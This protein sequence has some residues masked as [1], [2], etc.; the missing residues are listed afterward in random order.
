MADDNLQYTDYI[1]CG[2][3]RVYIPTSIK[4][5]ALLTAVAITN[6]AIAICGTLA[7]CLVIMSYYRNP[8]LR[9]I[10]STI[11]LLLAITDTSVTAFVQ[12]IF[13]VSILKELQG[14]YNC[15]LS[16]ASTLLTMFFLLLSM[17]T[18]VILS[19]HSYITLAYPYHW[20]SIITKSR[21]N[22][23]I[24]F[25]IFLA[26]LL[27]F[28]N[29]LHVYFLS[30][31]QPSLIISVIIIV[32]FVWCWTYKLIARHQ[33][34]IQTTQSPSRIKTV[35]RKKILRSTITALAVILSLLI[36]YL[37]LISFFIFQNYLN[38]SKIGYKWYTSVWNIAMTLAFL[39]SL[40]D[41]CLVFWRSTAFRE[42]V[43]NSFN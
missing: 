42:T 15:L 32:V 27:T 34:T 8:R 40:L 14:K 13:V 19:L 39:N 16:D 31:G 6:I 35:S 24:V 28:G 9:T 12:P 38:V 20:Q 1:S 5:I 18:I 33:N 43:R 7:N 30:Y 21:V 22:I 26:L 10:Q 41:P 11:F 3:T 17:E 36:C 29:Y 23:A 37:L 2:L 4:V 25:S